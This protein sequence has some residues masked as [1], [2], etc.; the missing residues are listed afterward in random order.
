[1]RDLIELIKEDPVEAIGSIVTFA[2][3]LFIGFM[4]FVVMG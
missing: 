4:L 1:M 3:I 2:G